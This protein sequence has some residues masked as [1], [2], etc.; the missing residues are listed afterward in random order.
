MIRRPPRSTLFPYTTLFR[1]LVPLGVRVA[2]TGWLVGRDGSG[3]G[4]FVV[5]ETDLHVVSG[6]LLQKRPLHRAVR[7]AATRCRLR[8]YEN[9]RECAIGESKFV[10][11]CR[12]FLVYTL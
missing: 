6:D 8:E 9:R 3:I 1:S 2:A 12:L 5:R 10:F 7:A 4:F 11:C